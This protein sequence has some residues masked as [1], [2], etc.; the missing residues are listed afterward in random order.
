MQVGEIN[1]MPQKKDGCTVRLIYG[2]SSQDDTWPCL[3][4]EIE[5]LRLKP[6]LAKQVLIR[7][8]LIDDHTKGEQILKIAQ[9]SSK[10]NT[11]SI[12]LASIQLYSLEE[13]QAF[14]KQQHRCLVPFPNV[15][16]IGLPT[17]K[18][19]FSVPRMRGISQ[20]VLEE[21]RHEL[22][23]F[24]AEGWVHYCIWLGEEIK[25]AVSRFAPEDSEEYPLQARL[26]DYCHEV[27]SVILSTLLKEICETY[28]TEEVA[29]ANNDKRRLFSL[30][31]RIIAQQEEMYALLK[32][33]YYL[34]DEIQK[35]IAL[36][37]DMHP[38]LSSLRMTVSI[39]HILL[40]NQIIGAFNL[41][42]GQ[43]LLLTQLLHHRLKIA[44]AI[45]CDTGI[46][47]TNFVFTACVAFEELM[48][49][50]PEVDYL[51]FC[52]HW[53]APSS[54]RDSTTSTAETRLNDHLRYE[55]CHNILSWGRKHN[56]S[57]S[58]NDS[59]SASE[60]NKE[61]LAFLPASIRLRIDEDEVE[62]LHLVV[63]DPITGKPTGCT[64]A[65]RKFLHQI[66]F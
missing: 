25:N 28:R 49:S 51:D 40:S 46:E 59:N 44:T 34:L 21:M 53:E 24:N 66:G 56:L 39:L 9:Q 37:E 20:F 65:G 11:Q 18:L 8:G 63:E 55:F 38:E 32:T 41:S 4:V 58:V 42:W 26:D 15:A 5:P 50:H 64:P 62:H 1:K 2:D 14:L 60:V 19:F 43:Q 36:I 12:R 61:M 47:R 29:A 3:G 22:C 10:S 31:K 54:N 6:G 30:E 45:N 13:E 23:R 57:H 7:S 17:K 27:D 52:L 16:H 35:G 33:Q 48:L